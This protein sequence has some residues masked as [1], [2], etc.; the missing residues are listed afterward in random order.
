MEQVAGGCDSDPDVQV[1]RLFLGGTVSGCG[2]HV[3]SQGKLI[4]I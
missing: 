1:H 4:L 2:E 3:Q